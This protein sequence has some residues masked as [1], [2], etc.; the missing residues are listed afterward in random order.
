[1]TSRTFRIFNGDVR[2]PVRQCMSLLDENEENLLIEQ[3][4][5]VPA[6]QLPPDAVATLAGVVDTLAAAR[7]GSAGQKTYRDEFRGQYIRDPHML[8][9]Q[10]LTTLLLDYPLADTARSLLGPRVVLRNSNVRITHPGSRDATIWHTDFRP[11]VSP[12][13]PLGAA[14]AVLV[15]LFYLDQADTQTGP[16]YVLPGSHRRPEQPATTMEP[17]IGQVELVMEPGQVALMHGALWHRGGANISRDRVRRLIT[18]Q[19]STIFMP[20]H[21]FTVTNPSDAYIRLVEHARADGDEAL[22]ELLGMG[23]LDPVRALY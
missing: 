22:L 5:V 2:D 21:N 20:P 6:A 13:P 15:A 11:H 19:L 8:D 1:M 18:V 3:G 9:P 7:F 16:L 23:G 14:P 17:L 4:T 10:F 12:P